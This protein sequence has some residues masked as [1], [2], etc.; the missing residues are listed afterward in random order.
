[1][2]HRG[3][4]DQGWRILAVSSVGSLDVRRDEARAANIALGPNRK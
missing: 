3:R 1:M 2:T 4:K